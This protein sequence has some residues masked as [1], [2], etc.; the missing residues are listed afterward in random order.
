M[1][2][3][4]DTLCFLPNA[5]STAEQNVPLSPRAPTPVCVLLGRKV[6]PVLVRLVLL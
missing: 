3:P 1:Y 4:P 5:P 2:H 6:L